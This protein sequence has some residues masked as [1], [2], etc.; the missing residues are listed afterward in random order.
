MSDHQQERSAAGEIAEAT[1][2]TARAVQL[3]AKKENWPFSETKGRGGKRRIY[4]ISDLPEEIQAAVFLLRRKGSGESPTPNTPAEIPAKGAGGNGASRSP[5]PSSSSLP[6]SS[7]APFEYSGDSLWNRFDRLP[8]KLKAAAADR[9]DAIE[10]ALALIE[11]G[12]AARQAW[13]IAAK[14][15]GTSRA[16]L[17][18][19]YSDC[20]RYARP[21]W[22]PALAPKYSGRLATA[23]ISPQ[24][25]DYFKADYLRPEQ[26]SAAACY[27]RLKA[28]AEAHGWQIPSKRTL[29]RRVEEIPA[30]QRILLR[31]GENAL[32]QMYPPMQRSVADLHALQWINGDGYLHN[33]FVRW[34]GGEIARPKSWIWQDVYS[35]KILAWRVDQSEHTDVIRQSIGDLIERFG[36]PEHAT[37]DNTRAA[38]NKWM[39]GGIPHRY[40]FKVKESDPDGLFK[41]LGIRV[42][43]T[44]VHAGKGH[45]QAKPVE[46]SFG[47]GGLGEVVDKHPALAGAYTGTNPTSKPDNYGA[48]AIELADFLE[49]LAQGI[50]AWNARTGRRTE[51]CRGELSFDQAF[52]ESYRRAP[53]RKGNEEQR[54]LWMLSAEAQ[55]VDRNGAIALDAGGAHGLGKNR[56]YCDALA[57]YIGDRVV[58]RFDPERLH[59]AVHVYTL[60]ARYIGRADCVMTAG[61]GDTEAG[62]RHAKARKQWIRANKAAAAAQNRMN[63]EA[64]A[65]LLPDQPDAETGE[66]SVIRPIFKKAAGH[67]VDQ[68]DDEHHDNLFSAAVRNLRIPDDDL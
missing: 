52:A 21:D 31:Q 33:V 49:V 26:P 19:W 60:D 24:A 36:I 35:R 1:G 12:S 22:L 64:A 45:G 66:T 63:V 5:S 47:V 14:R 2:I 53:I 27:E 67:D 41:T 38:A 6:G 43:W 30:P 65:R 11:R 42:H 29:E 54:R 15:A 28:A 61:F 56:Y 18:R 50:A 17:Q 25:W 9:L 7:P 39:T 16:T 3:R 37:I 20:K 57:Q 48:K 34:P 59:E 44:S 40:R 62:R 23:E 4:E 32:L 55:R 58:A 51:I 46:R 13:Q 10:N 68:G 8:E